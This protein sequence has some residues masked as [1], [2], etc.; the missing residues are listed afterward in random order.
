MKKRRETVGYGR[1][2]KSTQFKPGKSGNPKGRPT[3]SRNLAT[4]FADELSQKITVREG[5]QTQKLT[6]QRALIKSLMA[7][8]LSG[9]TKASSAVLGLYARVL[10]DV[11]QDNGPLDDNDLMIL[12]KFG[13][14][15]VKSLKGAKK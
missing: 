8:A 3:G 12:E 6:K 9:D 5:G 7:K 4:D 11:E 1:P 14:K 13:A 2:P 15:F 10:G